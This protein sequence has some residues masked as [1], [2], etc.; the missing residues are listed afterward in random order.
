MEIS[1]MIS[2]GGLLGALIGVY[3]K[4]QTRISILEND[5]KDHGKLIQDNSSEDK[6]AVI[7][8]DGDIKSYKNV[9]DKELSEIRKDQKRIEDKSDE[10]DR[11]MRDTMKGEVEKINT[12]F[13]RSED[14][15]NEN[16]KEIRKVIKEDYDS[17]IKY[18]REHER[19]CKNGQE[20]V[21]E[22]ILGLSVKVAE[23]GRK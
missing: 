6:E 21:N 3:V 22:K 17:M 16:D 14:K 12:T 20:K 1:T 2:L 7:K 13:R 11:S 4:L 10:S 9:S 19:D 8:F 15:N 18:L 23:N 5:Q